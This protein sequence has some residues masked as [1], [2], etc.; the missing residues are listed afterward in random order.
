MSNKDQRFSP[1][2]VRFRT[3]ISAVMVVLAVIV[4]GAGLLIA[5]RALAS[6]IQFLYPPDKGIVFS[7]SVEPAGYESLGHGETI[8]VSVGVTNNETDNLR[9][10]Y[11][12]DQI[13]NGWGVETVSASVDGVPVADFVYEQGSANEIY[14]DS[15]P[16]RWALEMPQ[17]DGVFSPTHPVSSLGGTALV[18]YR[19][20]VN[21]GQG[22]DYH[23]DYHGWAGWLASE[24]VGT[25]VYGYQVYTN[26]VK[27]DFS[28]VPRLG[29][30]P[31][32]VSFTD[33]SSGEILTY[34][35]DFGDEG[36]SFLANPT[37]TYSV[38]G[39]YT[40]SLTVQNTID[41]DTETKA[42][43]IRAVDTIYPVYLPI[44]I[45]SCETESC[46]QG[47]S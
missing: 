6:I 26:T 37:H 10:F 3:R 36:T 44:I 18:V 45:R 23:T 35:W 14:F 9:G 11:F 47:E 39:T 16:H 46:G 29:L 28:G 2:L 1:S 19:M 20:I 30:A 43:Y 25:T 42:R 15:T 33:L 24:P 34:T 21:G 17:G 27:A 12:S 41:S 13:P 5:P 32:S 7:H 38:L 4:L 40:V 22:G 8:T 31:L